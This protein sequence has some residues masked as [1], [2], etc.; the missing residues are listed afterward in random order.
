MPIDFG[1]TRLLN[2]LS[3]PRFAPWPSAVS[4]ELT[5]R[6]QL[7]CRHC[8]NESG[9]EQSGELPLALIERMLGEMHSWGVR[10][11]RL[12]GGE[13][14]LHSQLEEILDA[15][16][17]REIAVS[18]NT[19]GVLADSILATLLRSSID[20]FLVSLD[21]LESGHEAIRGKGT[22]RRSVSTCRSLRTAGRSV[23][24]ACHVGR[25]NLHDIAG[26]AALASDLGA[27]LK[28][29]PLR[30][31]GR[32]L[33]ETQNLM[34]QPQ[35]YFDVVSEVSALR[36]AYRN[37]RI[38]TD[39][40]IIDARQ[41]PFAVTDAGAACGAGRVMVS[42]AASGDVYPCAFFVTPDQRFSAGN[43]HR[44]SLEAIW[45]SSP[46][47]EPFRVHSK[48][49]ECQSCGHYR[50]HCAG[51]CPAIGHFRCGAIDAL[52]P[53]CFARLMEGDS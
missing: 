2:P 36:R 22:F 9:P 30:P 19:H 15:C 8:Y 21:G 32:A 7:R 16:K 6:C 44:D 53:T 24:I 1:S 4:L 29:S 25:H 3:P 14:T 49:P 46:V 20:R 38:L 42:I 41:E 48:A 17:R 13:P 27:D 23:T 28:L 47:F 35:D 51:G 50:R 26:L 39:F 31:V 5:T 37:I 40:D 34:P 10:Q 11:V 52:D 33:A 43:L 12:S 18:L 45:H